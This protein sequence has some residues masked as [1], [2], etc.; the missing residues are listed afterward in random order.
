MS[1]HDSSS[2]HV[3]PVRLLLAVW[4][5]LVALTVVTVGVAQF[6]FGELN[7][8]IAMAIAAVK[9]SL[10]VLYFMHM[11]WERPFNAVVFIA[12]LFFLALLIGITL[13]DSTAYQ[14]ELIPRYAPAMHSQ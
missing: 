4:G 1:K 12:S 14:P 11:R 6:D 3:V 8:V 10:V 2:P 9:G 13:L 5:A 7:I